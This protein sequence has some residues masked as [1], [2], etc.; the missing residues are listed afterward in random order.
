MDVHWNIW[1][2][3]VLIF[4]VAEPIEASYASGEKANHKW[5][6]FMGEFS[7][8]QLLLLYFLH[9]QFTTLAKDLFWS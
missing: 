2:L 4:F 9:C 8:F 5:M 7:H 3:L 6:N 1:S